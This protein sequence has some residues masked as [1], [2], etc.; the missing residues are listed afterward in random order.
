M[1]RLDQAAVFHVKRATTGAGVQRRSPT[2][3]IGLVSRLQRWADVPSNLAQR[4]RV[5]ITSEKHRR[6]QSHEASLAQ[7][8]L[9]DLHTKRMLIVNG[10]GERCLAD[11]CDRLVSTSS[12]C[13]VQTL[14]PDV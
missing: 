12:L 7:Q 11:A 8:R 13:E 10:C 14:G 9:V 1:L 6:G 3:T 5:Y 4:V 2:R